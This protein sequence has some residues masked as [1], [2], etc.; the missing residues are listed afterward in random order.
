MAAGYK[1]TIKN[2]Q[3]EVIALSTEEEHGHPDIT[4]VSFKMNTIDDNTRNRADSVRCEIVIEGMITKENKE[5]TKQ[6]ANWAKNSA[7]K[8]IYRDVELVVHERRNCTGEVLRRYEINTMF[9]ID[10]E[11]V[12]GKESDSGVYTLFLAQREGNGKKDVFSK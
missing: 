8:A 2:Q 6:L 3:G 9:V 12:F 1:L 11:E 10:Y 7:D 4:N 5:L